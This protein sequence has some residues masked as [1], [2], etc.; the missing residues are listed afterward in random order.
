M[1]RKGLDFM[2]NKALIESLHSTIKS[3][4]SIIEG[5]R[6]ELRKANEN[7]EYL[8]KKLYGRKTEKTAAIDGQLIISDMELGLL[9][10]VEKEANLEELEEVPFEGSIKRT[11][12][13]KTSL[14]T[15]PRKS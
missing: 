3:Q 15:C 12:R 7:M 13:E 10:E 2:D 4:N 1:S 5:L 6:E 8:I 14:K 9:N 11:T